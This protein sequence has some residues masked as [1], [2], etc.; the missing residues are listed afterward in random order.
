MTAMK[1][2]FK[3]VLQE[4]MECELSD[5]LGYEK[6]ERQIIRLIHPKKIPVWEPLV[7]PRCA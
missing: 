6:S 3:D 7:M 1:E 2:M 5:E 4:V